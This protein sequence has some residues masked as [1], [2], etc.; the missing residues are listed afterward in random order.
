MLIYW[1]R[2]RH[3]EKGPE[4]DDP[5][6]F[7][8]RRFRAALDR[9]GIRSAVLRRDEFVGDESV[10]ALVLTFAGFRAASTLPAESYQ[11]RVRNKAIY[12]NA[13][14]RVGA[15]YGLLELAEIVTLEGYDAITDRDGTPFLERRGVKFNWPYEPFGEGDPF[16]ENEKTVLDIE[17]WRAYIDFLAE[18]RYNLLSIWSMNPFEMMFRVPKYP[19]ATPYSDIELERFRTVFDFIFT[20]AKNR[21]IAT[22]IITWNL[23]ITP[24]IARGLGLPEQTA[25]PTSNRFR[26]GM[27]QQ[28]PLI[29]DYFREAIKTLVRTYPN[30]TGLGTSNSEELIG[31]SEETEEWVTDT[32]LAAIQELN[33][34]LPFIHRTNM[35]NG[36]VAQKQFIEKYPGKEKLISWKYS[37]AH[38]YSHPRP[39][40]EELWGA[41]RN[42]DVEKTKVIY[43]V[44]NDDFQTLRGA[45]PAFVAE[46]IRGMKK[47]YVAGFYW[48]ADGYV[49]ARDFQH[50]R[51]THMDW[52][53]DFERHFLQFQTLGRL[54]YQPD[55][56]REHWVRVC[57]HRYGVP[58]GEL[59]LRGL[60]LGVRTL[61]AVTRL[62]WVDYDFQWH[63]E[64]LLTTFGFHTVQHFIDTPSMPG[65]GTIGVHDTAKLICEGKNA[66]G[67]D[68]RRVIEEVDGFAQALASC[69]AEL[70]DAIEP[71]YRGGDLACVLEDIRAWACLAQYYTLKI[72]AALHLAVYQM[73]ENEKEKT[74]AVGEL[75]EAVG[76]WRELAD[77]WSAHYM[78]YQMGR[79]NQTFGYSYY[80]DDVRRDIE[81]ARRMKTLREQTTEHSVLAEGGFESHPWALDLDTH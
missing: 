20:H 18:N 14:D 41:W 68:A 39:Q 26:Q 12:L 76:P 60:E 65:S 23:R 5:I 47:S 53:Y 44:R 17:F 33:V 8:M 74:I 64:S 28:E 37:N 49:W 43:T 35:S 24:A 10:R 38:M 6:C 80:T 51:H 36:L 77:I 79:V 61:C 70:D 71:E 7:G 32:Y 40:F 54:G 3:F 59:I 45:D 72:S 63:P 31:T 11:I 75:E 42:M 16:R 55:L 27:R 69:V 50:V 81:I 73:S 62:H 9:A 52:K 48:G 19:D 29:R 46:Y 22:Y 56:P 25:I 15:M 78:P 58:C 67:E 1:D 66:D 2:L 30:L 57:C 21:G 34:P 13:S 4:P